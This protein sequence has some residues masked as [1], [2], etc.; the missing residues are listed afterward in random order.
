MTKIKCFMVEKTGKSK[1]IV[2]GIDCPCGD[3]NCPVREPEVPIWKRVDTGE[4]FLFDDMP[5]G[6][7][8][9]A[10]WYEDVYKG[11]DGRCLVVRTPAGDW[12]IDSEASNCTRKGDK[13]HRC[14]CR[15][16]VTPN[17]TVGKSGNTCA[18]G[19]GSILINTDNKSYH[20][21]LRNGFLEEC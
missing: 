7:M 18:A 1:K 8:W 15:D 10:P 20:G 4:E 17:I 6:A 14:W 9:Y 5:A 19:A 12:I 21:F 11:F 16:G 13:S 3:P 2:S